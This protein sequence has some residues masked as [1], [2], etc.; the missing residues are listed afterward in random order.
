MKRAHTAFLL[1]A[2]ILLAV[3]S[4]AGCKGSSSTGSPSTPAALADAPD[5]TFK[6]LQGKDVTL[7]SFKG[8]VVL[9]NFWGTWC[10]P[11]RGEIPI[12]IS[13]QQKYAS[14]GFTLLAAA[15]NDEEKTVDSF[16]HTTQFNVGGQQMLMNYPIVMGSDDIT[17]KFGGLLGMPTSYLITR[18]GKIFK[19]YIG[20]LNENQIVKDV[21]GQ[22]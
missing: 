22:L 11:C 15:T 6:D 14:R 16:I 3:V 5:V 8:K 20:A 18:D 9:V 13:M 17:T 2:A 12:L 1:A 7:S 19:R 21:E 10:E 4:F